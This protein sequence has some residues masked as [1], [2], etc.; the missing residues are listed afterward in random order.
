[1]RELRVGDLVCLT[2]EDWAEEWRDQI[3]I[4]LDYYDTR[5]V[6]SYYTGKRLTVKRW[7]ALVSDLG[8]VTVLK[9]DVTIIQHM[10]AEAAS[11]CSQSSITL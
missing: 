6:K 3:A 9:E 1:M 4:V 2:A 11:E 7:K 8:I 5:R 10:S